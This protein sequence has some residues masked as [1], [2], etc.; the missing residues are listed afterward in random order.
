[1]VFLVQN[2]LDTQEDTTFMDETLEEL[3]ALKADDSI[4]I[5]G[6][7]STTRLTKDLVVELDAPILGKKD[8]FNFVFEIRVGA[9]ETEKRLR[10][11]S[12]LP[13]DKGLDDWRAVTGVFETIRENFDYKHL[14]ITTLDHGTGYSLFADPER[15]DDGNILPTGPTAASRS[16]ARPRLRGAT[17]TPRG[18]TSTL[19]AAVARRTAPRAGSVS[20]AEILNFIAE[21]AEF[22]QPVGITIDQLRRAIRNTFGTADLLFMRNCYMG[23]LDT[24]FT[25]CDTVKYLVTF[26]SLMWFPA[27]NYSIWLK[28]MQ[29]AGNKL[30]PKLAADL[31]MRGFT[32]ARK[33]PRKF[34]EDTAMF[35]AGLEDYPAINRCVNTMTRIL[36]GY[37]RQG[38]QKDLMKVRRSIKNIAKRRN[39]I[40]NY[41][42]VDARLWFK[43]AGQLLKDK[44]EE[45]VNRKEYQKAFK[46]FLVLQKRAIGKRKYVG[47][48]NSAPGYEESGF[49]LYFPGKLE[50]LGEEGCFYS[51]YYFSQSLDLSR[52]AQASVWPDF[53]GLL[54]LEI[55]PR[56]LTQP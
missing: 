26:E 21:N 31:A 5:V 14:L 50:D 34:K 12:Q 39:P 54:F 8:I 35:G 18:A 15:D 46:R 32:R 4:A 20:P 19:R 47:E 23:M 33:I 43:K 10:V 28:A 49:S 25:L 52:F 29:K 1:M 3:L 56:D 42:Y 51:F 16:R 11:L 2:V 48:L 7:F 24:G 53:I 37:A 45:G 38:R 41:E 27:Y 36:I 44:P 30:T 13:S 22:N 6:C 9:P 40:G 55:E 17:S